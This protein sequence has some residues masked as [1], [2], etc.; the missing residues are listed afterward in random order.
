MRNNIRPQEIIFGFNINHT[1]KDC[2]CNDKNRKWIDFLE[3]FLALWSRDC[4]EQPKKLNRKIRRAN[5]VTIAGKCIKSD[6]RIVKEISKHEF[7]AFW[8]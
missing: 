4:W 3:L 5:E 7:W 8:V 6:A 1:P 2:R